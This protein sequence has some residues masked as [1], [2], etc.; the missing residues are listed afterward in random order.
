ML[1]RQLKSLNLTERQEK[2]EKIGDDVGNLH[3]VVVG[4]ERDT[5]A[6]SERLPGLVDGCAHEDSG[7]HDASAPHDH[8]GNQGTGHELEVAVGEEASVLIENR[9]LGEGDAERVLDDTGELNL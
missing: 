7:E 6:R 9:K 5:R 8:D 1:E 3:A 2:D 4:N